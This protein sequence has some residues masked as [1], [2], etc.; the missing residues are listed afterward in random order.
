MSSRGMYL[1]QKAKE[2][3]DTGELGEA[4]DLYTQALDTKSLSDHN[5]AVVYWGVSD[6]EGEA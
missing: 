2:A 6:D 3:H 1:A 5:L 4:I